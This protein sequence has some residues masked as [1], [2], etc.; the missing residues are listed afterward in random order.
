FVGHHDNTTIAQKLANLMDVD[1]E[2]LTGTLRA[3]RDAR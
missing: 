2:S 1:L 3:G